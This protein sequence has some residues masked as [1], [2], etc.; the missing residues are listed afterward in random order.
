MISNSPL[1]VLFTTR[2]I[3]H[4]MQLSN[5]FKWPVVNS[6]LLWSVSDCS[7][8]LLNS[9]CWI[10]KEN[11]VCLSSINTISIL[12]SRPFPEVHQD[13]PYSLISSKTR[14][15][16]RRWKTCPDV[17]LD[18]EKKLLNPPPLLLFLLVLWRNK[19]QQSCTTRS[20]NLR[21]V[22]CFETKW[23]FVR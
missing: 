5:A 13:K 23:N 16:S 18:Q 8:W 10:S 9:C 14:G 22:S 11:H 12:N 15:L 21:I 17:P 7:K 20:E 19:L 2:N 6:N 3:W 4:F 1:Q